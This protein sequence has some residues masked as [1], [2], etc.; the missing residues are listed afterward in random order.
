MANS[1]QGSEALY[2]LLVALDVQRSK[3][4]P[5]ARPSEVITYEVLRA[6]DDLFMTNLMEPSRKLTA[7]DDHYRKLSTWG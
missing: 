1:E 6:L 7:E 2:A 4:Q 5:Y 3:V